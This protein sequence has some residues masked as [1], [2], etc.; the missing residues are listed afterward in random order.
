MFWYNFKKS[1]SYNG[2]TENEL[3]VKIRKKFK[4]ANMYCEKCGNIVSDHA[5]YCSSC[6]ASVKVIPAQPTASAQPT[7]PAQPTASAQST[8][9][10]QSDTPVGLIASKASVGTMP[11]EESSKDN[12]YIEKKKKGAK[13]SKQVLIW[14]G[15]LG[16]IGILLGMASE[17]TFFFMIGTWGILVAIFALVAYIGY[18]KDLPK[19][20][21][22]KGQN[23]TLR[24][25]MV[26]V[27]IC[28]LIAS[29]QFGILVLVGT[30]V[31]TI[32]LIVSQFK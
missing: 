19:S 23:T 8:T 18:S 32:P 26:V 20:E 31:F 6:G 30:A 10:A 15:A 1:T 9:S 21:R 16:L 28:V 22:T 4:E 2:L 17:A 5:A 24:V 3:R 13:I 25:V 11:V 7:A 27:S 29:S 14:S 12:I